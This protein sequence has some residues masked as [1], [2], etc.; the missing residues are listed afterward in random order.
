[1]PKYLNSIPDKE[2]KE[3][4]GKPFDRIDQSAIS[5]TSVRVNVWT[6]KEEK[7]CVVPKWSIDRSY[8]LRYNDNEITDLTKK[9]KNDE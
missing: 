9:R 3:W 6:K 4:V 1:M 8:L 5:P 2:L 7:D